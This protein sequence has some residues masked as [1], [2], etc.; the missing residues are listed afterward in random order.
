MKT[1]DISLSQIIMPVGCVRWMFH[2]KKPLDVNGGK[3]A[4]FSASIAGICDKAIYI[5]SQEEVEMITVFFLPYAA[6]I[7]MGIPSKE[8][9]SENVDFDSLGDIEFKD[10]K[11]KVLEADTTEDCIGII[12]NFILKRL[13][14]SQGSPYLQSLSNAFKLMAANPDVRIDELAAAACLSERQFRRVFNDN[15]G[16]KPKQ[17]QRIQRFHLATNDILQTNDNIDNIL[18]KYGYTDH[19]H[20]N[21]EFHNIVGIS[22][23][24]YLIFL[25]DIQKLGIMPIYRSY[26]A[27]EK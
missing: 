25:E 8:F 2:R 3:D 24:E 26:H 20:F 14:N 22:P 17:I 19:S 21:H 9:T 1:S 18:Y 5:S 6:Q 27:P 15:V 23:S 7:I 12:E 13:V 4:N 16:M 11:S 10:L